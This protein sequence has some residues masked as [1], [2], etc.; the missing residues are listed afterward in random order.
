[1]LKFFS[2]EDELEDYIDSSEYGSP[3]FTFENDNPD[4]Y[5]PIGA[6]II[7]EE[8][9]GDNGLTWKYKLRFNSSI[10]PP[11]ETPIDIFTKNNEE[12]YDRGL[13]FY[14]QQ[15]AAINLQNWLDEAIMELIV[16]DQYEGDAMLGDKL[17]ELTSKT[18][19]YSK[20]LF[21]FP[22]YPYEVDQYWTFV[23]TQF[24]FFLFIMFCYPIITVVSIL[25]EEKR[26]KIKEGM[27]DCYMLHSKYVQN[28]IFCDINRYENDGSNNQCILDQL[29]YIFLHRIHIDGILC[30]RGGSC[31]WCI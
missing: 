6:A 2:S 26:S 10:V 20:G 18:T 31:F 16:N 30:E 11:T 3:G 19:E 13:R 22:S 28:G 15:S 4:A 23:G 21:Q 29:E 24:P 9:G 17:D 1:M 25:V 27:Y 5:R 14:L 12:V 7:F 8:T